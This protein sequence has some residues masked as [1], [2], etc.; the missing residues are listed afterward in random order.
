MRKNDHKISIIIPVYNSGP[1]LADCLDS[2][3][4]QT[5]SNLE[6]ICVN[7]GSTDASP[8]IL[9][10]YAQ[11]DAR[12][13]IVNQPHQ[14]QGAARNTAY[15]FITGKYVLFVDSDDVIDKTLCEK[16]CKAAETHQADLILFFYQ[17]IAVHDGCDQL[18]DRIQ[19]KGGLAGKFRDMA[20]LHQDRLY[21][22]VLKTGVKGIRT[23]DILFYSP[24]AP[25]KLWRTSFLFEN[26]IRFPDSIYYEDIVVIFY[27]L[28]LS[29]VISVVPERLYGYRLNPESSTMRYTQKSIRDLAQCFVM[30]KDTLMRY[31]HY[32]HVLKAA[33]LE[34][35][36]TAFAILYFNVPSWLKPMVARTAL[37][38]YGEDE[39][40][41][42]QNNKLR[43]FI[44]DF[45]GF[46]RG[47]SPAAKIKT[48]VN[49]VLYQT[50][51]KLLRRF[52]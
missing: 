47:G 10:Q 30:I 25:T 28:T 19:E 45:Y 17:R 41:F 12:L 51:L 46:I 35:K 5:H 48:D 14:G 21:G 36:L 3:L 1:Y 11:K 32:H 26:R 23:K 37:D 24:H 39:Q 16:T 6:I 13:T 22:K 43:W 9:K 4:N 2:V 44:K 49:R 40:E 34:R 38:L 8:A 31:G 20:G 42:I 18:L 27:A 52:H 15:P 33:F 29:P 50:R 7:D